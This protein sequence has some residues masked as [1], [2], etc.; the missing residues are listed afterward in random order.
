MFEVHGKHGSA[1]FENEND[2]ISAFCLVGLYH[3]M[4]INH[5]TVKRNLSQYGYYEQ[6]SVSILRTE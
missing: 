6:S 4:K 3:D 5:D 1:I 2:A